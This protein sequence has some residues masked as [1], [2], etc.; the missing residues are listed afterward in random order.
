MSRNLAPIVVYTYS[1]LTH[2]QKTIAALRQN[3]LAG[4]ST[5]YVVSDAPKT[6]AH[7]PLIDKV[8]EFADS[9]SGF[10]E[11]VRIYRDRNLGTPASIH[12]AE[13]QV[14]ND[15]GSVIS[16]E[17]D[18]VSSPNYLDFLNGG[19]EAYRDDPSAFSIC[20]FCPPIPI[21]VG[22]TSEYWFHRWNMS[23]GY[24][25]WKE[26]YY[27]IYPLINQLDEFKREGLLRKV[28]AQGGLCIT[29]SLKL[30]YRKKRIYPDSILC[31]KMI[32]EGMYSVLPAISKI[33]NT[34]S[35]GTGVS[36]SR[37]AGKYHANEDG[38][39]VTDF[40]FGGKPEMND[41][42]VAEAI[43]FYNGSFITRASRHLGV[44]HELSTF[45]HWLQYKGIGSLR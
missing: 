13:E 20:G 31:A 11:V 4:Q 1:R 19:L 8:R 34:G 35:D 42:L 24:A 22:F 3:Y 44:Y 17:D 30:D 43:K 6:E 23:W 36:G 37:L 7:K 40:H 27:R 26:K 38:R 2:L 5:L 29:D 9:I 41:L 25:L 21:P 12:Q 33:R 18:N 16:M 45:K 14:I 10:R 39:P 15:H 28:R 32:R